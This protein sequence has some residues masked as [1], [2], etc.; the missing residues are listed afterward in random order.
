ME[1][2]PPYVTDCNLSSGNT[3]SD[4]SPLGIPKRNC[5]L[6]IKITPKKLHTNIL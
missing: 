1:E 5:G 4:G 2:M 3:T 6:A